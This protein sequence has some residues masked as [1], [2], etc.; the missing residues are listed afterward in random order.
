[1]CPY[2]EFERTKHDFGP[3]PLIH[4]DELKDEWKVSRLLPQ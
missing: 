2:Y 3:C 4:D 1:M